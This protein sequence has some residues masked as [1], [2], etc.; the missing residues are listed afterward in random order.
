M[1]VCVCV[2]VRERERERER[3]RERERER[4][5]MCVIKIININTTHMYAWMDGW[6][7][8]WT[9]GCVCI[10]LLAIS[11]H[12]ASGKIFKTEVLNNICRKASLFSFKTFS[13]A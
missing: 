8:G 3:V 4:V 11:I 2:C 12:L 9:D 10:Y 7:D 5:C 13:N 1:C 6:M